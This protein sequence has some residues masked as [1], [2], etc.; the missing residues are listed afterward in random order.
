MKK[1]TLNI[2]LLILLLTAAVVNA[3]WVGISADDGISYLDEDPNQ[4]EPEVAGFEYTDYDT[5]QYKSVTTAI[6]TSSK[7]VHEYYPQ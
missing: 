4:P 5:S 1:L 7:T 2:L 3:S 6:P